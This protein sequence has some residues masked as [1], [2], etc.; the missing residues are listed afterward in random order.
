MMPVQNYIDIFSQNRALIDKGSAGA[1]NALRDK[2]MESLVR[3]GLPRGVICL[4][5]CG[6]LSGDRAV[7]LAAEAAGR[8][9][10]FGIK[11]RLARIPGI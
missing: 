2:A 6:A 11:R 1:M 7:S 9:T 10:L 5:F 3:N 4:F 8:I